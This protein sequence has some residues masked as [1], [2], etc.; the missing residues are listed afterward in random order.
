MRIPRLAPARSS[1]T[2]IARAQYSARVDVGA[3]VIHQARDH[4]SKKLRSSA[5]GL[6]LW[7]PG[8]VSRPANAAK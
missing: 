8:S 3:S 5:A 4:A 6:G 1:V 7:E 2:I